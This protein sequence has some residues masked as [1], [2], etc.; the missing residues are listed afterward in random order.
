MGQRPSFSHLTGYPEAVAS[1]QD[2]APYGHTDGSRRA[3]AHWF[4]A[5]NARGGRPS[6]RR[7]GKEGVGRA[8]VLH[9]SKSGS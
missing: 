4:S 2:F 3:C 7:H 5:R 1:A 8:P 6:P 9:F